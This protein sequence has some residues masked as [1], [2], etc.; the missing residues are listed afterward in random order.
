MICQHC[1]GTGWIV[2]ETATNSGVLACSCR[3]QPARKPFPDDG[4]PLNDLNVAVYVHRLCGVLAYAPKTIQG[5]THIAESLLAMCETAAEADWVTDRACQL[6]T[7]WDECGIP[8]LRQIVSSFRRPKDGLSVFSTAAFPDGAP[9]TPLPAPAPLMLPPGASAAPA[10]PEGD[11]PEALVRGFAELP[12]LDRDEQRR[13]R[14]FD[15]LLS[16]VETG[17]EDRPKVKLPRRLRQ[18]EMVR[19]H[20]DPEHE[21]LPEG[22][23][24]RITP[25]DVAAAV[26]K[27]HQEKRSA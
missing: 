20:N 1:G 9:V 8:G 2:K 16:D 23:Y 3:Q 18:S 22:S 11:R 17:P 24:K 10:L 25:D 19:L 21:P 13:Q 5:T 26:E 6:Y 7:R 14:E 12:E 4:S 15:Q 27:L